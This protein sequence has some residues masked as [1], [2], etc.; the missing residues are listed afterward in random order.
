MQSHDSHVS[1][2]EMGLSP[3]PCTSGALSCLLGLV[4]LLHPHVEL[5]GMGS[6]G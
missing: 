1:S 5:Y 2:V 3:L 4:V 6:A